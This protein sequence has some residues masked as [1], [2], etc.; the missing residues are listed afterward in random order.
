MEKEEKLPNSAQICKCGHPLTRH[1][2]T[3]SGKKVCV[4]YGCHC[5]DFKLNNVA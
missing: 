1:I 2:D 3:F 5:S 4:E